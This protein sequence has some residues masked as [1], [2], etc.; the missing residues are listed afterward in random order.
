MSILVLT[1]HGEG[2]DILTHKIDP[3]KSPYARFF[4]E[5]YVRKISSF[6]AELGTCSVMWTRPISQP[7]EAFEPDKAIEYLLEIPETRVIAFVDELTWSG[8]LHGK[9]KSF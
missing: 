3:A 8:Y 5:R 7:F 2:F 9:Y 6:Y 4:G 1:R